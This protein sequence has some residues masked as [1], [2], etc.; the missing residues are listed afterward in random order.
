MSEKQTFLGHSITI[1]GEIECNEDL[2]LEGQY[3][4]AKLD[5]GNNVFIVGRNAIVRGD[6]FARQVIVM[7]DY[8]GTIRAPEIIQ[9]TATARVVGDL[10]TRK[11]DIEQGSFFK[12]GLFL[13]EPAKA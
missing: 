2:I 1:R 8:E 3:H 7:G 12:G 10:Y 4:G 9:I 6:I 11:I 5:V 13:E